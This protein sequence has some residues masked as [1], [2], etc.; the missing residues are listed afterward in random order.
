[1]R[2]F[3]SAEL[4]LRVQYADGPVLESGLSVLEALRAMRPYPPEMMHLAELGATRAEPGHPDGIRPHLVALTFLSS[5]RGAVLEAGGFLRDG[6]TRVR[7][8]NAD[9][10]KALNGEAIRHPVTG[11]LMEDPAAHIFP[12]Y[13][14]SPLG[15]LELGMP[16]VPDHADVAEMMRG[17]SQ[18]GREIDMAFWA[19][20]QGLE[21]PL[22]PQAREIWISDR[23]SDDPATRCAASISE[24]PGNAQ[25]F[26]EVR[27]GA[28]RL[29]IR[30]E[31]GRARIRID[32]LRGDTWLSETRIEAA[33]LT[34]LPRLLDLLAVSIHGR[35][36]D[37]TRRLRAVDG[38]HETAPPVGD[39]AIERH[40]M[41]YHSV[42][43]GLQLAGPGW[44]SAEIARTRAADLRREPLIMLGCRTRY[45]DMG[46]GP[47]EE[48]P[49]LPDEPRF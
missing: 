11:D 32:I 18:W 2:P 27:W 23:L 47:S 35:A 13:D 43:H 42:H 1:M 15:R 25:R 30:M 17:Q 14:L 19:A 31:E 46:L 8:P 28:P 39:W 24:A 38:L 44:G 26:L 34:G 7:V 9:L 6:E 12:C 41:H 16:V 29:D 21:T 49:A 3:A 10:V 20:E 33:G 36:I 22:D 4:R 37:L 48:A 5:M 45:L 40:G